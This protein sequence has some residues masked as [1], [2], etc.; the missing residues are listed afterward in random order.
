MLLNVW[1]GQVEVERVS[2]GGDVLMWCSKERPDLL[3]LDEELSDMPCGEIIRSIR[4]SEELNGLKILC[5]VKA[6]NAQQYLEWDADGA[7]AKEAS[8]P[9]D[10]ASKLYDL[11]EIPDEQ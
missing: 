4:R 3:V 2:Y 10:L 5:W 11:L 1:D 8:D 9:K 6:R 7:L